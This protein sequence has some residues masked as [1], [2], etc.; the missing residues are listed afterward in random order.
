MVRQDRFPGFPNRAFT[1]VELLVVI[2]IIAILASMLFPVFSKAREKARQT[3]CLSNERQLGVSVLQYAQDYDEQFPNGLGAIGGKRVW[4][5]EGWAGQCL[6]YIKSAALCRCPSDVTAGSDIFN[7]PVSY[8]Y[9]I[10]FVATT[11]DYGDDENDPPPPGVSLATLNGP[12]RS[13]LMY[14]VSG[15]LVNLADGREGADGG[16]AGRNFSASGNGLDNRLYGQRDWSTRIENQYETGYLG[17][18]LPPNPGSTQFRNAFG[19]HNDG[20]NFL[21]ADGHTHWL[22]GSA[23][24]SGLN[25]SA[26]DCGQDNAPARS[27]CAGAFHAAGTGANT[28]AAT[29]SIE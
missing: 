4:A 25:A 15:V 3:S 7:L 9:N 22:K 24:S 26:P 5:G 14:E 1:L 6:P 13:V 12:S 16:Q 19:R 23:I 10:N 27:G 17:G 8:A 20:S 29:F 2:A 28:H 18:R 11:G 21:L